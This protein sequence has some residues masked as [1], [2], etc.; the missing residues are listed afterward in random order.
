ELEN[1]V[2]MIIGHIARSHFEMARVLEVK[3]QSI[4][5][6][7]HIIN[8]MPN[9]NLGLGDAKIVGQ[10]AMD[11]AK[12]VTAYLGSIADLEEAIA[13]NLETVIKELANNEEEE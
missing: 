7:S 9:E 4:M 5:N 12:S 2:T 8:A 3:R 11:I 1:Q 10:G 13:Y 6:I